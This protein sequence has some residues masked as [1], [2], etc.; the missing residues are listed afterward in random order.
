MAYKIKFK[1]VT[2]HSRQV[3][4]PKPGGFFYAKKGEIYVKE[5]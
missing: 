4:I 2:I 5:K 1:V 3:S